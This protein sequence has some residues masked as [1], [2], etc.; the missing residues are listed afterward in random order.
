M[1]KMF[2]RTEMTEGIIIGRFS[3]Q[4]TTSLR[5]LAERV[6]DILHGRNNMLKMLC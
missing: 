1:L 4:E 6:K 3:R 5:R 2:C